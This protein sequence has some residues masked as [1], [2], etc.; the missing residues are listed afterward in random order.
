MNVP[1]GLTL[2]LSLAMATAAQAQEPR[3]ATRLDDATRAQVEVV[4][5]SARTDGLPAEPIVDRVLEGAAKGAPGNLIARAAQ[6]LLGELRVARDAFGESATPAELGA[7]ASA[8]RAGA[9]LED[10]RRLRT[11]RPE[12]PVIVAASVLAD[13]V[14]AGVPADTA[15]AAVLALAPA[16]DD[17]DYIAFRRSVERDIALGASP[18]AALGVRLGA[19]ADL[20]SPAG[21]MAPTGNTRPPGP[22]RRKP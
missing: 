6:R 13:L 4:L 7:G 11:R 8:L 20:A 3:L 18:A 14:A 16:A 2:A 1:I 10:L 17:A 21:E 12:Q 5:D 19:A 15:V 22:R 9:S